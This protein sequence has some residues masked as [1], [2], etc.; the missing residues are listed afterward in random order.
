M[1]AVSREYLVR[2]IT[3]VSKKGTPIGMWS[4]P[5]TVTPT[6]KDTTVSPSH[7][8][9]LKGTGITIRPKLLEMNANCDR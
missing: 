2:T 8:M 5:Q 4:A 6:K 1:H 9:K 7:Q 3:P